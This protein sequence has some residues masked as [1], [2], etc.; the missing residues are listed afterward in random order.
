MMK[1]IIIL[2]VV[3]FSLFPSVIIIISAQHLHDLFLS[4][5][6]AF[7]AFQMLDVSHDWNTFSVKVDKVMVKPRESQA[8]NGK[9]TGNLKEC[10]S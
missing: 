1:I 8:R 10:I 9:V 6:S 7:P 2:G 3:F 5:E 4:H